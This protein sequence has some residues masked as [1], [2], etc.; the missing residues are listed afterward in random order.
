M[1]KSYRKLHRYFLSLIL[2]FLFLPEASPAQFDKLGNYSGKQIC[3]ANRIAAG[4]GEIFYQSADAENGAAFAPQI[5]NFLTLAKPFAPFSNTA[6][7]NVPDN[8]ALPALY[9]SPITVSGLIGRIT[10]VT[11]TLNNLSAPRPADLDV[12]LVAPGGQTLILMS[13]AGG[14][15]AAANTSNVTVTFDDNA[16]TLLPTGASTPL[17]SG[18]F[19]P[20]NYGVGEGTFP[21]AA[22][23]GPYGNPATAGTAT[24]A[25]TF[26][27]AG[28]PA[29]GTWNLYVYDDAGSSGATSSIAGGWT[30]NI[31]TNNVPTAATVEVGGRV[32]APSGRGVPRAM[33]TLTDSLGENRTVLTNTLGYYRFADVEVGATYIF[34]VNSKYYSFE[35]ATRVL[36]VTE[37]IE[38]LDFFASK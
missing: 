6:A 31:T 30:L 9:P 17:T 24:L 2:I 10:S 21:G 16:A 13:D 35:E 36:T 23:A 19:H 4:G 27:L 15:L 38:D 12:L 37:E 11:V 22:P 26:A 8:P 33:V 29:N 28:V 34:S 5:K 1:L 18:G 14:T 20:T 3:V 25:N 7:I 32:L